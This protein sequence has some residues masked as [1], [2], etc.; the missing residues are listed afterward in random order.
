MIRDLVGTW[1]G[2]DK[3]LIK[4]NYLETFFWFWNHSG[5]FFFRMLM[6]MVARIPPKMLITYF[7]SSSRFGKVDGLM[8]SMA[9]TVPAVAAV[10]RIKFKIECTII[11]KF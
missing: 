3:E 4:I 11:Y 8:P 6:I 1:L 9:E 7:I 2:L 10:P 5:N